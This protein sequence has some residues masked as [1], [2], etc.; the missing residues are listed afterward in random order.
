MSLPLP[1]FFDYVGFEQLSDDYF[2]FTFWLNNREV[3]ARI[4]FDRKTA[5]RMSA[6]LVEYLSKNLS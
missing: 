4:A 2:M 1:P 5:E 3:V 6:L